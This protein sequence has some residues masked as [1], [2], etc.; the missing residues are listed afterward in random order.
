MS[1][2]TLPVHRYPFLTSEI[3]G[4]DI[5]PLLNTFF[6]SKEMN[7]NSASRNN[8]RHERLNSDGGDLKHEFEE[9]GWL[10][11]RERA[12]GDESIRNKGIMGLTERNSRGSDTDNSGVISATESIQTQ[13]LL[14]YLFKFVEVDGELNPVL[15]GYFNKLVNL[16][17]KRNPKKVWL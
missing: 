4:A 16:L 1:R 15:C 6:T 10:S 14:D 5:T 2:M 13:S 9:K 11:N 8:A 17:L 3:F 7:L 12:G